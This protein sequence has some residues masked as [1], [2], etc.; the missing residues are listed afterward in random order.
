MPEIGMF[1]SMSGDGKRGVAAWPKL[2]HPSSTL[3]TRTGRPVRLVSG[4]ET[5][6]AYAITANKRLAAATEI[7]TV[8]E[9]GVPGFYASVWTGRDW[10]GD[11]WQIQWPGLR[12]GSNR[13]PLVAAARPDYCLPQRECRQTGGSCMRCYPQRRYR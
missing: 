7:P 12:R 6:K 3:P 11:Y 4:D 9:G 8:D 13:H 5:I 2:P 1:G 10:R